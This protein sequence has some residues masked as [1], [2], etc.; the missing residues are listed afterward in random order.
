MATGSVSGNA[1]SPSARSRNQP[2]S[3]SFRLLG[4]L[5]VWVDGRRV[6]LPRRKSRQLLAL[7]L[8]RVGE[9]LPR[10]GLVEELW[11]QPPKAAIG[12]LWN[13][14]SELRRALGADVVITHPAGYSLDVDRDAVDLHRFECLVAEARATRAPQLRAQLLGRA[15]ALWR[16]RPLA[17][18]MFEPFA[19]LEI[20]RLEELRIA[21]REELIDIELEFG[22][23]RRLV[24]ELETLVAEHP[25]R[26]R[27]RAQLMVALY[28]SGRQTEALD[29]YQETRRTLTEQV[30]LDP[31]EELQQLER[32]ILIHDPS[33]E[34]ARSLPAAGAKPSVRTAAPGTTHRAEAPRAPPVTPQRSSN[35]RLG[36]RHLIALLGT[37]V[38]TAVG[39]TA[40]VLKN[41][42][43]GGL[44]VVPN[45]IAVVDSQTGQLVD[46]VV[47]DRRPYAITH[48]EGGVWVA[49]ADEGTVS[50]IDPK[51]RKVVSVIKAGPDIGDLATGFGSVWAAG[52]SSGTVIRIDPNL[53]E[54]EATVRLAATGESSARSVSWIATG[55][56]AVWATRG[57]DTLME[58]DPATNDVV[59][60]TRI[61]APAGLA[62]GFGAAW[63]VTTD[64]RLLKVVPRANGGSIEMS[65][66]LASDGLAPTVGGGSV[67]LIVYKG[68]GEIWQVDPSSGVANITPG[69][70]RYPLDLAVAESGATVWAVDST[71]AVIHMNP[72]IDLAIAKIR[73]ASTIRSSISIGGG[74]VWVAVQ[75]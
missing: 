6:E 10:D 25:L 20:A 62:A 34:V 49:N 65:V 40:V 22:H 23:H 56:G 7:L 52:G 4:P 32:A 33:L 63:V 29:V 42:S 74:A 11:K 12:S 39:T 28:R 71:G 66:D 54:V 38:L 15:L 17:D 73:T 50:H 68:T 30:G 24:S 36:R 70:G 18:F 5:E 31:G 26:E 53:K 37:L 57:S 55:A 75:D 27:L 1:G 58:I 21:V 44:S 48:G 46:D 51:K 61:P 64:R 43:D 59:S 14:I 8:L 19:Q 47:L 45:S 35:R 72:N 13:S 9:V 60:T 16:G 3:Y 2:H 69:A 67:W 41:R